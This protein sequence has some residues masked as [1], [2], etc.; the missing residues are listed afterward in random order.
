MY[1]SYNREDVPV[2][3][4]RED[5]YIITKKSDAVTGPV[6]RCRAGHGHPP[7]IEYHWKFYPEQSEP[8]TRHR[9][10]LESNE[11]TLTGRSIRE[12]DSLLTES[13]VQGSDGGISYTFTTST[14]VLKS[15]LSVVSAAASASSSAVRPNFLHGRLECRAVNT[16]GIQNKPCVYRITGKIS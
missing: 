12:L 14:P 5:I 6:I 11:M 8:E 1:V 15:Y 7:T 4:H 2:C 16:M 9:G 3:Q 13:A 10:P